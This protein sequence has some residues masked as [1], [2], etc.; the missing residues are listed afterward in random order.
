[1]S[2]KVDQGEEGQKTELPALKLIQNL[3]YTYKPNY[4]VNQER[5][6]HRQALLYGRLRTKLKELNR[7]SDGL[8]LSDSEIEDAIRQIHEDAFSANLDLVEANERVRTK[9]IGLSKESG[10]DEP[11]TVKHYGKNGLEY[12]RIK[13]FD[14]DNPENNDFLATNQFVLEGY[15]SDNIEADIV[16]FVNGIP[17]VLIECKKPSSRDYLKEAWDSNLEKYQ[18]MGLGFRKMFYYNHVIIATSDVAA[19]YGTVDAPPNSYAKWTSLYNMSMEELEQKIGRMPTPQ[20]VLL[21]GILNPAS[22]LEMLKNFVIYEV[23]NN[24]RVKKVAKH[25]QYRVVSKCID[26][27]SKLSETENKGGVIW[28]TQGSGK[29]I[30][31][32][33]FA[34]QLLFKMKN[35]PILIVTDRRQ[36]DAQIHS[37]FKACGFPQPIQADNKEHLKTELKNPRGKT[38]MSTIQKFGTPGSDVF[39]NERVFVLVDEAHRTQFGWNAAQMRQAMPNAVFFGFSGTPIDKKQRSD[40]QVFGPLIDKYSFEES[41][42]DGATLPVKHDERMANLFLEDDETIDSIFNRV[43]KELPADVKA[44]LKQRYVQKSDIAEA[45]ERIK[46]IVS[47]LIEHFNTTIGINGYKGM[48]VCS[49]REAAVI[50]HKEL[51]KQGGPTSKIIMTSEQDEIGKD[52]T[53]WREYYLPDE[54]RQRIS[55]QFKNPDDPIKLL[56]VVDMLLVGYDAPIL[57]VLYLDKSLKE[58]ALLQAMARVNRLYD[59]A[60]TYGLIVDY[61]GVAKN[62][63]KALEIFEKE[64]IAGVYDSLEQDLIN[65]ESR[66]QIMKDLIGGLQGKENSEIVLKFESE[67]SQVELESAFKEL[68]KALD[69]VLPRKE[70]TKYKEFFNFACYVRAIVRASY[71]SDK[72]DNSQYS[73]KIQQL[74]DDYVRSSGISIIMNPREITYENFLAFAAKHKDSAKAALVKNKAMQVIREKEHINPGFYGTLRER[75]EALIIEEKD[76]RL[77]SANYFDLYSEIYKKAILGEEITEKETGIKDPFERALYYLINKKLDSD[78]SKE[79][80]AIVYEKIKAEKDKI[81]AFRKPSLVNKMWLGVYDNLPTDLLSKE[82]RE[83]LSDEVIK[84]ARSHFET[85]N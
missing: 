69:A 62:L 83:K 38:I 16:I 2:F 50:Y 21:A 84:L 9:L 31:M 55:E 22:L 19:K 27:V 54:E 4:E 49:S 63:Q 48:V 57:Q 45:P 18:R 58:H 53:S 61:W 26:A 65:L 8:P 80:A 68:S 43:F 64:D 1:M 15:K 72:P 76:R 25:Q 85:E 24:K 74:I 28:H 82:E 17:L 5:T 37:T 59:A 47:D 77:E 51:K 3:G 40:F 29:S 10:L 78:T 13:F 34:T 44:E 46:R 35:P 75:L 41:K 32:V 73:K 67:D 60:K 71:Y 12:I 52:G 23:V 30:S 7:D 6:D 79:K 66:T 20:D 33:W 56:I 42:N 70:A 36:L 11:I 39:T 14:F 81:D